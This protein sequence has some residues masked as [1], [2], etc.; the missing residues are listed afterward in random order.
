[1]ANNM[2]NRLNQANGTFVNFDS[3]RQEYTTHYNALRDAVYS[4]WKAARVLGKLVNGY[5]LGGGYGD[6]LKVSMPD[7]FDLVIHLTFP[8]N[9]KIIATADPRKPGNVILDMSKVMATIA[10][11]EH[12][13]LVFELLQKIVNSKRQLLE[14]KLQSW[15]QGIMTQVLSKMGNRIEV[16]GEISPLCYKKCGPAHTIFVKGRYKYSV[17]FVPAIK[18]SAAQV[19]LAP[20][21]KKYFAGTPYWD[22]IPKPMKPAQNENVSFRASFYDAE[23]R[24]L[25]GKN[26]LK[27]A[28]RLLK[29]HRNVKNKANLKSYYIKTL[30]LWEAT[31]Q[32]PSY[33]QKPLTDIMIDMLSKLGGTLSVTPKKGK[34]PFFWDPKLDMFAEL[35]DPQRADMFNCVRKTEYT[36]KRGDGNLTGDIENNVQRSFSNEENKPP[37]GN[38]QKASSKP[39]QKCSPAKPNEP[40]GTKGVATPNPKPNEPTPRPEASKKKPVEAQSGTKPKATVEP[41]SVKPNPKPVKGATPPAVAADNKKPVE[42]QTGAKPKTKVEPTPAKPNPKPKAATPPA[43]PNQTNQNPP[44]GNGAK[45]KTNG[46]GGSSPQPPLPSEKKMND[47]SSCKVM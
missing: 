24:L 12:N 6:N 21:Q 41:T 10:N 42:A 31:R 44:N 29:Q 11:Q 13:K 40:K 23:R 34:L 14:D 19:V 32:S 26:N 18:L 30:F 7:E 38:C 15:L 22:A 1:M 25:H 3:Y 37:N 17:D 28:I 39:S 16:G 45:P 9:D 4:E 27:N 33:W 47:E 46:N 35:T 2:E 5:T 36:F 43:Q 20:E 8:E